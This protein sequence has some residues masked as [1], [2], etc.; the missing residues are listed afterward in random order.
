MAEEK[1]LMSAYSDVSKLLG[2]FG[3]K[4][5]TVKKIQGGVF[6]LRLKNGRTYALKLM[7]VSIP[8]LRWMDRSLRGV[9]RNGFDRLSWRN[10]QTAT[11]KR[12]Y[13]QLRIGSHPGILTPWIMGRWPSI[14]SMAD[15]RRSGVTLA[16]YHQ[17]S[18]SYRHPQNGAKNQATNWENTLRSHHL[19]MTKFINKSSSR[20]QPRA[21][22]RILKENGSSIKNYSNEAMN[23]LR[24]YDY[25]KVCQTHRHLITLCHG[26]VGPTNFIINSKGV[27]L[28]DF[29]T[30]Q[31]NFRAYD[32]YRAIYNSCQHNSWGLITARAILDGYQSV[33]QL[34]QTDFNLLHVLLRFPRM[35]YLLLRRYSMTGSRGKALVVKALPHAVAMEKKLTAFI[36]RLFETS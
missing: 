25:R 2:G 29:E 9:R 17:A 24:R 5:K 3:V 7:P 13:V 30:L 22:G 8:T 12:L 10:E 35:T 27:H 15:M 36:N 34:E 16:Q 11:G 6:R 23:L 20:T 14:H 18:F 26:D 31:I 4:A 19:L 33:T 32:L 28:I 21:I 1:S